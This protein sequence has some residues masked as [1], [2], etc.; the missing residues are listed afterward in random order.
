MKRR[1]KAGGKAL[2]AGRRKAATPGRSISSKAVPG[3]RSVATTQETEIARLTRELAQARKQLTQ[4][5]EQQTATSEIL[6]VISSSPGELQTVFQTLLGNALRLCVADFGLMF[7]RDGS[8]MELMAH[9][10]A[11]RAYLDY[12]RRGLDRPGPDTLIAQVIKSC[13]P[14]QFEDYAKSAAYLDRD[15][16]AVMA[17]ERGGVR[18][19]LGVPMLRE[20]ELIGAISLYRK[21]VRPFTDKQMELLQNFAAQAVIAIENTRLLSE[22]RQRTDDLTESLEQ[23]TATSEVL[24][25]IS[26]SQ[27]TVQPVFDAVVESAARLC[28]ALS[29]S[30]YL[31]DGDVVVPFAHSGPLGRQPIGKRLPLN[32]DWVTGRAVLEARSIHVPDLL[33]SD[34]YPQGKR[35]ALEYGHRATLGVPLLREGIAIG[36]ILVRRREARPFTDKQIVLVEDFAAQAVIAIENT[37]LLSELR[38]SLERQTATAKVLEV[39]SRAAFDLQAVFETVVESSVRLCGAH[40]AI[41]YRFDGELL[42]LAAAYNASQEFK[43]WIER[44]PIRPGRNTAAARASLERRM[45]HIPDVLTD[46]E[47]T[48]GGRVIENVRTVLGV[49]ILKGDDLLG[50]MVIY[51]QEVK[52]FTDKQI[53]LVGTFADQAAIA[54]E[55]VRLF[56]AEQQRTRELSESLEQQTATSDVLRVISSSTGDLMPVFEAMLQNATRICGAEF[57]NLLLR[58]GDGFRIGATHGAPAAYVDFVRREGPFRIDPR[59]GLSRMLQTKQSYQVADI[60]AAPTHGDKLRIATIE[61]AGART[62]LGVPML[63][64]DHMVGSIIIYRREVRPFTDK[65]IELMQNFA[66]QA[67]IAIENT[68]LLSELRESL[69]QQTATA[70][71]LRVI[72]S[73]TGDLQPVFDA[74]LA[75][76][77]RLCEASYGTLWLHEGDGQMRAAALHGGLPDVYLKTWGVGTVFHPKPSV[78]SARAMKSRKPVQLVDLME[79][80]SYLDGDP[81]AVAAVDVAGIRTI[82]SVPM[83]KDDVAVGAM[84]IYRREVRP[85]TEKQTELVGNFA[86]QAVIAIENTRLINELRESLQQQTATADVL[87]VISRSAFDLATVLDELLKSAARLCDSD[88]GTITQRKGDTFF[89]TVS[90]GFP[91]AFLDYVKDVPVE[92]GRETGTG[93]AL[94]EGHVI[95]IPDVLTDPDYTWGAA[96]QLGG[97][98]TLLGVPML[99]DSVSVGVLTLTRTAVRPF[100]D[101]Q[102]EL[103]SIFA[104]QA[105]IAIENVR[106][107]EA[108]QQ[109]TRE[110]AKSLEDLRAAQDRLVQTEKLASLGQLTAGI[111]HEI[112]NPLNFVNNFSGVSVEL[113][114]ELQEVVGRVVLPKKRPAPKL[115]N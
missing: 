40:R 83:V 72:S 15:P 94:A 32:P 96:Q 112:K 8:G 24:Q 67:V 14:V 53:S 82:M 5:L 30:I 78:P 77:T 98:R 91:P 39:I 76:A 11:T 1:S 35:D 79:D 4:A 71:V 64:D 101:K 80:K 21:E 109:R 65:Q 95:H 54:I 85:F 68:R 66:A 19:I 88:Q 38:E 52:P 105:A 110:L 63:K 17:V 60:A 90:Y 57:G 3:R 50:A 22:L 56:E 16:L 27:T 62:V 111:A 18:T 47:Y 100:T 45:I 59:L 55:N 89:R 69:D 115:S 25:V 58:E 37:R 87:K 73:S 86:A 103:V 75:N 9:R 28:E 43:E 93:R 7:Q 46:P 102:I 48:Y 41:I 2:K 99:R 107:F 92:P 97:F 108:E 104:D 51:H 106:L 13:A 6:R 36:N 74:M 44:N 81:L 113:I 26:K 42:R 23:Q 70:D 31:R 33:T 61:L 12:M 10:G 29:A 114:D 20:D 34:E 84:T 49:P